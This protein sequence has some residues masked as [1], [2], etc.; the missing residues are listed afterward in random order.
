[1]S[2]SSS[3]VIVDIIRSPV[4]RA[5]KGSLAGVRPDDLAAS[6]VRELLSRNPQVDP[7]VIDDVICGCAF[8]WGEQGYNLGRCISI[9]AGLPQHVPAQTITR[10]CASSLQAL[11]SAGHAIAVGEGDVFVVVGVESVSRVGRGIEL[12]ETN[13]LLDPAAPG[14]TLGGVFMPMGLTAELVAD[15]FGVTREEMD[16]VAQRSQERAVQARES[17]FSA[18]EIMPITLSDGSLFEHDESPRA[19]STPEGLATLEPIFRKNGRVTAGNSCPLNDGAAAALVMSEERAAALGLK[20]RARIVSSG[21]CAVDPSRMGIGPIEAIKDA[22]ARASL[23]I[24][25]IDQFELNEAFA[26]QVIPVCQEVGIDPCD[27]RV[28]P[29]GGGIAIGHPFGMTGLRIM[30]TLLNGLDNTGGRFGIESMCIGGGQGQAMVVER[31]A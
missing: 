28:N 13:P 21:V 29:Y 1:M 11:R 30:S 31:L 6:V 15:D 20:P 9:L 23:T 2:P 17:G 12:S 3:A 22:L 18:R 19:Q 10:L 16:R 24:G 5:V 14:D 4:G 25:E 27:D 26:A 8:P 7:A